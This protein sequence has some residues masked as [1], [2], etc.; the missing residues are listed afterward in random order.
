MPSEQSSAESE[1]CLICGTDL[2]YSMV[3]LVRGY[4]DGC[5]PHECPEC[6]CVNIKQ[7]KVP[8]PE[9]R[10]EWQC[11]NGCFFQVTP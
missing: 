4:C 8:Y 9:G 5:K 6:G 7:R 11:D 1:Q 3:A 2:N 10:T